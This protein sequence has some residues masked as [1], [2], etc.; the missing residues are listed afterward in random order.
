M[1]DPQGH[2]EPDGPVD[3]AKAK[4]DAEVRNRGGEKLSPLT[5]EGRQGGEEDRG[6]I[7]EED[8]GKER[9]KIV[10]VES[11]S[12]HLA[13]LMHSDPYNFDL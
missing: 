9:R 7:R 4:A 1:F 5:P 8:N 3:H 11:A 12:I 13:Q 6:G 10:T 2:R